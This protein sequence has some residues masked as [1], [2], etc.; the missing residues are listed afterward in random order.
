MLSQTSGLWV[1]LLSAFWILSRVSAQQ[2]LANKYKVTSLPGV[3]FST[4]PFEQYAGHIQVAAEHDAN[5]FFWKIDA[6]NDA[7]TKRLIIWLNGGPGCSSMDGLFMENGPYRVTPDLK[8]QLNDGGWNQH[9]TVVFVD[10]PVGTGFSFSDGNGYMHNMTQVSEEFTTFLDK[11]FDLFPSLNE[12]ELY[13]AGESF[14]GTYIPYFADRMLLLNREGKAKYNLQGIAIGNGWI[15]P[16]HQYEAYYDFG[17]QNNLFSD[18]LLKDAQRHLASCRKEMDLTSTI[19]YRNCE[20]VLDDILDSSKKVIDGQNEGN[21]VCINMYDIRLRNESYPDCGMSWPYDLPDVTT[22]LR[23][24]GLVNAIHASKKGL[25]W[26]ECSHGVSAALAGDQSKPAF[27]LMP[28]IISEIRVL[29][30]SGEYD[31]ICNYIGTEYMIGNMTWNGAIGFKKAQP[32]EW[33]IGDK[34]VGHYTEERNLT[35][36]LIKD[37]SHMVPYDKPLETLDMINRF[38]HV[39]ANQVG[40]KPSFVGSS[41][42]TTS[43]DPVEEKGD[44]ETP[45]EAEKQHSDQQPPTS[46]EADMD[47]SDV[48]ATGLTASMKS[49]GTYGSLVLFLAIV[50]FGC[51]YCRPK[52]QTSNGPSHDSSG[53]VD[54]MKGW[55][56]RPDH[57]QGARPLRLEDQDESNELDELVID[58]PAMF[59]AAEH[60][61]DDDD[62]FRNPLHTTNAKTNRFAIVEEN[63]EEAAFDDFDEFDNTDDDATMTSQKARQVKA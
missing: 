26:E 23:Q 44:M 33:V 19:H 28:G 36:V 61:L 45:F 48:D 4:I 60:G 35:Y 11:L 22:Y 43:S 7:P 18:S 41:I 17:V 29:L 57:R 58:S 40:G 54:R 21:P 49:K 34:V 15:S 39:G 38:M 10:Q 6:I 37:G 55:L 62:E 2:E 13:I 16:V 56:G 63:D 32:L 27:N 59:S 20:L 51:C 42:P 50:V 30:F 53:M 24:Q 8:L 46:Q 47:A 9:A 1:C 5:I 12:Q 31:L 14:A 52:R 3:D 25:G